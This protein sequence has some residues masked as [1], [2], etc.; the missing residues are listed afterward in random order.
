MN[1]QC[2]NGNTSISDS[3]KRITIING[4]EY[5]WIKGMRGNNTTQIN[6]RTYIDG[7]E[8][9]NGKWKRTLL[10]LFHLIF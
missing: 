10:G 9:K 5:P 2:Q 6:E 3:T 4:V 8:L 7:Y 1:Y